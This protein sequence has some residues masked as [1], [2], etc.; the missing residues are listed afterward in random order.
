MRVGVM[1][2]GCAMTLLAGCGLLDQPASVEPRPP[3]P[4]PDAKALVRAGVGTLFMNHPETVAVA[5]PRR[6]LE[7]GFSV[8]VRA[9]VAGKM[10]SGAEPVT[11]LVIIERG[12]MVDRHRATSYDRCESERYEPVEI[13]P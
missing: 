11:M 12:K 7:R 2:I 6:I 8:C 9:T 1:L 13:P 4:E 10:S 5:R 3:E